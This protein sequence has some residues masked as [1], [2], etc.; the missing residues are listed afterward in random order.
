MKKISLVLICLFALQFV[1]AQSVIDSSFHFRIAQPIFSKEKGPLVSIDE[2]HNN[3]HTARTGWSTMAN[4][5]T[6]DGFRVQRNAVSFTKES[7][8]PVDILVIVNPLHESNIRKWKLP[9]PSAFSEEE[10]KVVKD[11]VLQGGRLFIAADHMPI[12]GAVQELA[13]A[14]GVEWGNCFD[15]H[16][17]N[18]WPPA[19]FDRVSGMLVKSVLTDSSTNTFQ[20]DKIGTFTG[21]AFRGDS[22]QPILQ[23]DDSYVLKY[24][25]VAWQFNKKTKEETAEGWYQGAYGRFGKGKV[26]FMGEAA[27]FT[28]QIRKRTKIGMN[29]E[30]VPDNK[31]LALNIFR[32]LSRE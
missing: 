26:V 17:K 11:W 1:F 24:P 21:S 12:G 22:L 16:K 7:L 4:L 31:L 25:Q 18:R 14:F 5:L 9:C 27:M 30:L 13:S 10:I 3:V 20:I 2:A 8:A 32:F 19:T 28:A 29:S 15:F 23:F 6:E